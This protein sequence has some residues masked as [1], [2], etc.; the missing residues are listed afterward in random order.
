MLAV[1]NQLAETVPDAEV[2]F[3]CDK[4]FE[5]QT[6]GIME[7]AKLPVRV[8]VI[9]S[10]RLRRYAHLTFWQ[11]FQV[12]GLVWHNFVDIF[13][14]GI[15]FIQSVWIMLTF[16]PD[17]VFAKGGFVCLPIGMAARLFRVPL[18]IHDSD[19]RVGLT[20]RVLGRWAD[21]IATGA[22][23]DNYN[24][25]EARSVYTGVPIA[26]EFRPFNEDEQAAAKEKLGFDAKSPLVVATGGG[27]GARSINEA[28]I[29]GADAILQAGANV[30]HIAGKK[31]FDELSDKKP[32]SAHYQLV[33][34]VYKDMANVLGAADVIVARG[35]ATFLQEMAG[36]AKA[37]VVVPAKQ[38]GDQLKNAATYKAADAVIALTDDELADGAAFSEEIVDL[39]QDEDRRRKLGAKL[40]SFAKP[41]AA[42]DLAELILK[43]ANKR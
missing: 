33:P 4:S 34:F 22:P 42:R 36:M 11:H 24:Y 13:K 28:M 5:S 43:A 12:S 32:D 21:I 29:R 7:H 18:V 19:T 37:V 39:L 27:L 16:R 38:L 23:L 26:N 1:I 20:N 14:I 25:P 15:G 30:F 40:H 2:Q 6:R 31:H 17:V 3:V 41:N 10:G 35:S 8:R 9:T